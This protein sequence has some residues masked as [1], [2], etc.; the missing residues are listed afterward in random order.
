MS[1]WEPF[2]ESARHSIVLAQ[3]EARRLGDQN[4]HTNHLLLGILVESSSDGARALQAFGVTLDAVRAEAEKNARSPEPT[5]EFSFSE[6]SKRTIEMAFS[7]ARTLGHN[8][9]GTEHLTLALLN[10]DEGSAAGIL[11][12]LGADREAIRAQI[13][14]NTEAV[15]Q[16]APDVGQRIAAGRTTYQ[17]SELREGAIHSDALIQLQRWLDEAYQAKVVEPNAMAL[18]TVDPEGQPSSRVVLL[19]KL[20]ADGLVFYTSYL[21]RKAR[22]IQHDSR[23]SLLFYWAELERQ[24]RLEGTIERVSDEQSDA[25]FASRPRGHQLSAWA[26]D[27]SEIVESRELLAQRLQQYKSRFEGEDVPRPHSWGGYVLKPL[28]VEFWQ[29]RPDRLHDRLLYTREAQ[30]WQIVRLSP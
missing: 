5:V 23:A 3:E 28:R 17:K 4:I 13:M 6:R 25:Y 18:S 22:A 12:A 16:A 11:T 19:R 21:S 29:G 10:R 2:S 1:M 15:A 9:I 24:A 8:Y 30:Q 20:D 27:Q 14:R 7:E 26:S